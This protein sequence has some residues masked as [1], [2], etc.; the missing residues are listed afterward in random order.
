MTC[1]ARRQRSQP[2][3]PRTDASVFPPSRRLDRRQVPVHWRKTVR[4]A[5]QLRAGRRAASDVVRFLQARRDRQSLGHAAG[6]T[7]S[8]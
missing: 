4:P 2:P 7:Q 8:V 5:C 1:T 6:F 3:K